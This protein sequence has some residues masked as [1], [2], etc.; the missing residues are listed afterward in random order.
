M[1]MARL[2]VGRHREHRGMSGG[3]SSR[4]SAL[5]ALLV[6]SVCLSCSRSES[7][8]AAQYPRSWVDNV[9]LISIDSLRADHL[10]V[11]GYDEPTSPN[12]D[13]LA[14]QGLVFDKAYSTTSWTLPSHTAMLTGLDDR[15]H[16]VR[17]HETKVAPAISTL[18]E[19]L[20]DD[21]VRTVGFYSGPYLHPTFGLARGFDEYV[22]CSASVPADAEKKVGLA[23]FESFKDV[24]NPILLEKIGQWLASAERV[25]RNFF[26][27]HMWDV[28]GH[29]TPP[30]EYLD[31]FDPGYSGKID[32]RVYDNADIHPGMAERDLAHL[33]AR[34]DG[35]IRYT[36][37]TIAE[38]LR[39]FEEAGLLASSAVIVVSDHGEEFLEH[40]A[41]GHQST[42]FEEVLRVPMIIQ[43]AGRRP[44]EARSQK[45]VSLIDVYPTV[46]ELLGAR[47]DMEGRVSE[48]LLASYSE[49]AR[50][51]TRNDALAD[52]FHNK[53]G[54]IQD[55]VV[56]PEGKILRWRMASAELLGTTIR[57]RLPDQSSVDTAQGTFEIYFDRSAL[58]EEQEGELCK[59]DD[60]SPEAKRAKEV[61]RAR[62]ASAKAVGKRLSGGVERKR[63][64]DEETKRRLRALGYMDAAEPQAAP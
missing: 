43:V 63:Q 64:L 58:A 56:V 59:G 47:C 53:Y 52:L 31:I 29:Y 27:I 55:A 49:G 9:I 48:S 13:R 62:V 34:Y 33:I 21:D 7:G 26:F 24:T 61:L 54:M 25:P 16:G 18:A 30:Q 6:L 36:D 41:K 19:E 37:D 46:C 23:H 42:L 28:H 11:Y 39:S 10:G 22:N 2:C 60:P 15:A 5:L 51:K 4:R 3:E 12:L 44:A 20:G 40:A 45:I 38:I 17:H 35:E 1:P 50:A 8:E 14:A 32:G 57:Q